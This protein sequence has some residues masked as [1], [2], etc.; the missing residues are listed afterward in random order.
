MFCTTGATCCYIRTHQIF[1]VDYNVCV[2]S[3]STAVKEGL[4]DPSKPMAQ[5]VPPQGGLQ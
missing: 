3:Q 5:R 4:A 1:Y 2:F